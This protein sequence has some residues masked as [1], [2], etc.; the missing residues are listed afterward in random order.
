MN[1]NF[2]K[3]I[4]DLVSSVAVRLESEYLL[5]EVFENEKPIE[6]IGSSSFVRPPIK[7][8][9]LMIGVKSKI[10]NYIVVGVAHSSSHN[11]PGYLY[12]KKV[13]K[14]EFN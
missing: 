6:N 1:L 2:K 10:D 14:V 4:S 12:I 7:D 13:Q 3:I 5:Y 11:S 9:Y 8:E